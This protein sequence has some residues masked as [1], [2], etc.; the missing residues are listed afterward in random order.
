MNHET[1]PI[2][3]KPG[4]RTT[5]FWLTLGF[6][7]LLNLGPL[8]KELPGQWGVVANA[9]VI[10]L[11]TLS[12]GKAKSVGIALP[13]LLCGF[14]ALGLTSC[15][16]KNYEVDGSGLDWQAAPVQ[17][18]PANRVTPLVDVPL[19]E[20]LGGGIVTLPINVTPTK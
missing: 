8:A 5:E 19:P 3:A 17:V 9:L 14:L 11:Y 15:A 12:R 1:T 16:V 13:L 4:Y 6:T 7:A 20:R 10:G 18:V 2:P